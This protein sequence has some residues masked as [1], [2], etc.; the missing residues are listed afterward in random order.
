MPVYHKLGNIPRK[1]HTVFKSPEGNLYQEHLVGTYGFSGPQSLLY[2]IHPPTE[3][4]R[5]KKIADVKIEEDPDTTLRMRHFRLNSISETGSAVTDR[6][7]VLFNGDVR[8]YFAAQTKTDDFYYRNAQADE[9]IYV[10]EG[11]GTLESEFGNLPFKSGDHLVIH[12]SILHK[13]VIDEPVKLLIVEAFGFFKSPNRYRNDW[14]QMEEHAPYCERD[15]RAPE[16]LIPHDEMGEF[17]IITKRQDELHEVILAHHPIDA[18]G[19]DGYYYPWALSIHDFEPIVGSL[20]QPPPVHQTFACEGFVCCAFVPRLFDFHPD[21]V[22]APYNHSNVMSD[23]VLYYA[24]DEFMSR[25]GIEYGSLTLHPFG[26]PHGPQ[27]GKMEASIGAKRTDE[28]AF[29][30]D[31]FKPLKVAKNALNV[32]DE[33][34]GKSW[35]R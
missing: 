35:I 26:L 15:I 4:L 3:V 19:W 28:L 12:R 20:H 23:E 9:M 31:T 21:A 17:K 11:S 1:R 18:V 25:K 10:S 16:E 34:Y 32:E 8:V 27:P 29:M 5:T 13:L 7:P 6:I 14:G 33:T 2:R 22:P 24:N 30:L